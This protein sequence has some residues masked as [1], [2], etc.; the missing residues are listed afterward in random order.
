VVLFFSFFFGSLVLS[1]F[2]FDSFNDSMTDVG[3][4][5]SERR[6]W[7]H[8]FQGVTGIIF[9]ASMSEFVLCFSCSLSLLSGFLFVAKRYDQVLFEDGVTNRMHEA[10]QLFRDVCNS[11]WFKDSAIILFLNKDDLFRKKIKSVPLRVCF[12]EYTGSDE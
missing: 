9:C 10:L 8:C 3:G 7:I 12:P 11:V 4:Q 5:R 1:S 2:F 6:K